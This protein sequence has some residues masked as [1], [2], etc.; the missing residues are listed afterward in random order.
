MVRHD[1]ANRPMITTHARRATTHR[2]VTTTTR[3]RSDI[4]VLAPQSAAFL[5]GAEERSKGGQP[6]PGTGEGHVSSLLYANW[7]AGGVQTR[8]I[9]RSALDRV[10][11]RSRVRAVTW[12]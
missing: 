11:S 2:V 9:V 4:S 1:R 3:Q 7:S 10:K 12:P 8:V 6:L 5:P